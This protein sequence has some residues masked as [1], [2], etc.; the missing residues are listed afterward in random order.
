MTLG[1]SLDFQWGLG[2]RQGAWGQGRRGDFSQRRMELTDSSRESGE[3]GRSSWP[4]NVASPG[5]ERPGLLAFCTH[6][7]V[8]LRIFLKPAGRED[9]LYV[10]PRWGGR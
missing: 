8:H 6:L 5:A 10:C 7:A 4:K 2:R 9:I 3:K 1:F